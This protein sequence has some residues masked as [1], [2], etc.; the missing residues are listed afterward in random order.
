VARQATFVSVAIGLTCCAGAPD[1]SRTPPLN[2]TQPHCDVGA[3]VSLGS[4]NSTAFDGSPTVSADET[5]LVFTSNR[6]GQQDIF[7][8]RRANR[9]AEWHEPVNAGADVNDPLGD[10]FSLRLSDDGLALFFASTRRQ[11]AGKADLY[12]STRGSRQQ[13]WGRAINL[14][15]PLN[16]DA[17][18]AFP[19][20]SA[21]GRSLYFNRSTNFDSDDSDI[22][23][24]TRTGPNGQWDEPARLRGGI[25]S[26][27]AEFSPSLSID[28]QT[29]WLASNRRGSIE[30]WVS[31]RADTTVDWG[32]PVPLGP[33]V[34][35]PRAM[36]LAPF[37]SHDGRALYFMSARPDAGAATCRA[38]TC[39]DRLDLYVAPVECR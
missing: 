33:A 31:T 23:V 7:I 9:S 10:D 3:G 30:L 24:S 25:N 21:D 32:A 8:A 12:V 14:G 6:G 36:T 34:N 35:V 2:S 4:V 15:P 29:M 13:P 28:G 16:T 11:G 39:F 38:S 20:P 1:S 27:R 37:V 18:E 26:E 22:W 5:E 19:T 17:F